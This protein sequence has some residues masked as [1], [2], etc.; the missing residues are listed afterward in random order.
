MTD[1]IMVGSLVWVDRLNDAGVIIDLTVEFD[2][3]SEYSYDTFFR[4][5]MFCEEKIVKIPESL[6]IK[7]IDEQPRKT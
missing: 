7:L 6:L 5:F 1:H 2:Y 4:V 3:F